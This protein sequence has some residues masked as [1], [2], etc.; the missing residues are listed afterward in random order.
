MKDA[1]KDVVNRA[2]DRRRKIRRSLAMPPGFAD[3]R[4]FD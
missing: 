4:F 1:A 2:A 3:S